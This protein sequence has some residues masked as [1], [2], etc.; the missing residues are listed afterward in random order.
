[1][2]AIR[3]DT[4]RKIIPHLHFPL[5]SPPP[6]YFLLFNLCCPSRV[7]TIVILTQS[8]SLRYLGSFFLPPP[9]TPRSSCQHFPPWVV[10]V[11]GQKIAY[12]YRCN[13]DKLG[14][15]N[16]CQ[17]QHNTLASL[18]FLP[19]TLAPISKKRSFCLCWIWLLDFFTL[20][21]CL[22]IDVTFRPW[23]KWNTTYLTTGLCHNP[24]CFVFFF[25]FT[26]LSI[27]LAWF[28]PH[29]VRSEGTTP[30]R[31]CCNTLA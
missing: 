20:L 9:P 17:I 8:T 6:P 19:K 29:P 14:L 18:E 10:F 5:F 28:I 25:F 3:W 11:K 22:L 16:H 2:I 31:L 1:M 13:Q 12:H 23:F 24:R 7:H 27:F 30:C 15:M 4:K 21:F 26:D